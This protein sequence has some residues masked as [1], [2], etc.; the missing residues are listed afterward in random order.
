MKPGPSRFFLSIRT[1]PDPGRDGVED[2]R[3]VAER[4]LETNGHVLVSGP[5][6]FDDARQVLLQ[7]TALRHEEREHGDGRSAVPDER[8]DRF[9]QRRL[10]LL[11]ERELDR[12]FGAAGTDALAD[13]LEGFSPLGV[14][15]A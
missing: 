1:D 8:G 4:T 12:I 7:V 13:L 9:L 2:F 5:E 14:A 15:G 10:H 11:E 6:R 3:V